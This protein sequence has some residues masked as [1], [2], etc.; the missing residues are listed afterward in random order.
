MK[1]G[2]FSGV[3]LWIYAVT[4]AILAGARSLFDLDDDA[5]EALDR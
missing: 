4:A 5:R 2:Q 3:V 1:I